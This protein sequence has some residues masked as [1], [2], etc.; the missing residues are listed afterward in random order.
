VN[1]VTP[2]LDGP[3]LLTPG[4]ALLQIGELPKVM[5]RVKVAN[6]DK[7]GTDTFH[8]LTAGLQTSSPMSLPLQEVAGVESVGP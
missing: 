3:A 5:D 7:P 8:D 2:A 4:A 6:L 1:G